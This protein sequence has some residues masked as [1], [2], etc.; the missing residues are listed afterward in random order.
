MLPA[1]RRTFAAPLLVALWA[2]QAGAQQVAEE[3]AGIEFFEQ[4]I[5][6]LLVANCHRCHGASKQEGNLRLDTIAGIRKGGDRGTAIKPGKPDESYLIQAVRYSDQ[7]LQMPPKSRLANQQIADL[8][9]WV[10]QGAAL[11]SE[12]ET[13]TAQPYKTFDLAERKKH[14]CY[15]PVQRVDVPRVRDAAWCKSPI[16]YFILAKLEAAGLKP[17]AAADKRTLL[18]RVTFD[19]IGL[20]PTPEELQAFVEDQ[21]P[22]AW[23]KVVDR[24]LNSPHYGERWGRHWLDLVRYAETLGHEF[25]YEIFHAWRYRDYVIRAFNADVPYNQFVMEHVAG[26]LLPKPRRNPVNGDNESILGTGFFWLGEGKHSPVDIRQEQANHIDNQID[27]FGKTFLGQTIACARCHDHKFD[28]IAAQDYYS[29]AGYLKSTRYQQAAIDPPERIQE[30]VEQLRRLKQQIVGPTATSVG[31]SEAGEGVFE[32]FSGDWRGWRLTGEA[33]GSGPTQ[34]GECILSDN[35]AQPIKNLVPPGW[36]HSGLISRRLEGALRSESFDITKRFIHYL[37]AG[38]DSRINLV[39]DGFTIIR[40]PIYGGLS[41]ELKDDRPA[42]RTMDVSMWLGHRAYIELIDSV[43]PNTS[44]GATAAMQSGQPGD[45]YLAI[46]EIRFSDLGAPENP[47]ADTLTHTPEAAKAASPELLTEYRRIEQ[48]IPLP[49]YVPAACDGTGEDERIFNRGNYRTLGET[50]PRRLLPA[51]CSME[52]PPPPEGSGRLELAQR[53]VDPANPLVARVMI[54]RI[55]KHHFG[56]GIVRSPDD[57]GRMGQP[58]THPELLDYLASEFIRRGWSIKQMHR[59]MLLSSTYQATANPRRLEAEAIRDAVL[60]VSGRLDRKQFG[61]SVMPHLTPFME[62]RGRPG[63]SGPLDGDGR[64]SI[65]INVR[66]NFLTPMFLAFDYPIPF[67][68]IG[69]R[70]TSNVPAQALAMMNGPFVAQEAR[71]WAQSVLHQ[72]RS[73][74]ERIERMYLTALTR[75]PDEQETAA[76]LAFVDEQARRYGTANQDDLRAWTD[77]CHVLFNVKEF[78]FID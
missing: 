70:S 65:Y 28:A 5:R 19:L 32:N 61:P 3:S 18:R 11:P 23:K 67:T 43:V 20:P 45:G 14:W 58:P 76:A 68:T 49:I 60:A 54:N 50:A 53:L 72:S 27:V 26:D 47:P 42:W 51:V 8:E 56:Q 25:D 9:T 7:D 22:D 31:A 40:A 46:D 1:K 52:Q 6:P 44:H 2:A 75:Q 4:K 71:R 35:P 17:A 64:R 62:G 41:V 37:A 15:Q 21:S 73:P 34:P 12:N 38:K 63:S 33:F 77:L 36:A 59:L 13:A 16:D 69:R 30:K 66:R 57:F 78:T 29:L 48:R 10:R 55:W 74:A 39:I 24:L